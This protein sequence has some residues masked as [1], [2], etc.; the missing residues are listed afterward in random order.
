MSAISKL[1][2]RQFDLESPY[3]SKGMLVG[4]RKISVDASH[5]DRILSE[6]EAMEQHIAELER[7]LAAQP[8]AMGEPDGVTFD[9]WRLQ[10]HAD[11]RRVGPHGWEMMREAYEYAARYGKALQQQEK[12]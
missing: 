2:R 3:R 6:H 7:E 1:L 11:T 10:N 4:L 12:K 5:L 8:P 9:E